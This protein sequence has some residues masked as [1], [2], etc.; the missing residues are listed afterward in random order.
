MLKGEKMMAETVWVQRDQTNKIVGI[1]ANLQPGYAEERLADTD[2]AVTAFLNP[3]LPPKTCQLW[4]LQAVMTPAQWIAAQFN[5]PAVSA[6]FAHG[7]NSIPDNSTTLLQLGAAIGLTS[8]QV[9]A[10]VAKAAQVSIP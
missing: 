4:Q 2:P 10:L 5:N 8:D 6:F 9:K 3:P 7:T 1:Y